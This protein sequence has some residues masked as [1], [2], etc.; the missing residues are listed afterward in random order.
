MRLPNALSFSLLAA[1]ALA[2]AGCGHPASEKECEEILQR[3]AELELR[4]RNITDPAM[5]KSRVEAARAAKHDKLMGL[6]LGRRVTDGAMDCIRKAGSS[7]DL[8]A[9]FQ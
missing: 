9:C 4:S 7:E 1:A 3:S 6:C 2:V 5:I 8:E